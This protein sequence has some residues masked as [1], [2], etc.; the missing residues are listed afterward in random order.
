MA[1]ITGV[2][3]T[4]NSVGLDLITSISHTG[5][6]NK[7][8]VT[9]YDSTGNWEEFLDGIGNAEVSISGYVDAAASDGWD[10][11]AAD[12]AAGTERAFI[13]A[14]ETSADPNV[15]GNAQITSISWNN[16]NGEAAT[17]D[18]SFKVQGAPTYGNVA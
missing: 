14:G 3:F 18:A 2:T 9:N 10:E 13:M 5:T 1:K 8:D 15:T 7:I 6:K 16:S 12:F 4:W 11:L 17:F